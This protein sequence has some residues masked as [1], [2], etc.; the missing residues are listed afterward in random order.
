MTLRFRDKNLSFKASY[1]ESELARILRWCQD[2]NVP[3]LGEFCNNCKS[4]AREVKLHLRAD[5]RPAFEG[6]LEVVREAVFNEYNEDFTS[7]L[8]DEGH[9]TVLVGLNYLDQAYEVIQDGV[10]IGRVFFDFYT[11][12]WRFKP[13]A[14][15]C[16]RLWEDAGIGA[17]IQDNVHEK[18]EVLNKDH[19][20]ISYVARCG[21]FVPLVKTDGHVFGLGKLV[22]EDLLI[23]ELWDKVERAYGQRASFDDVIVANKLHLTM[24]E[25]RACKSLAQLHARLHKPVL[26]SYSGGKDSLA[27]LLIAL[28][29]GLEPIIFFND[30]GLELPETIENVE[31]V[32]SHFGLRLSISDAGRSFWDNFDSFGPPARDYRWCCK[33]CKLIPTSRAISSYGE[34]LSLV[35]QRKFESSARARSQRVWRNHWI[36]HALVT[37]PIN[38]WSMLHVW[39]YIAMRSKTSVV[40]RLYFKGFDR[41]GCFMCPACRI[42]EFENVRRLHPELWDKWEVALRGWAAARQL[43]ESWLTHHMWRWMRLPKRVVNFSKELGM[44]VLEAAYHRAPLEITSLEQENT[45][46]RVSFNTSIP[47][48]TL[49]NIAPSIGDV[50]NDGIAVRIESEA[51]EAQVTSESSVRIEVPTGGDVKSA[52]NKVIGLVARSILCRGCG[53]CANWCPVGAIQMVMSRPVVDAKLCMRC[54]QGRCVERCPVVSFMLNR[55]LDTLHPQFMCGAQ[56]DS[57]SDEN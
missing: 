11:L 49:I 5:P 39:L 53:S 41:I 57:G 35:G 12:S 17:V 45:F 18:N 26:V 48:D 4:R 32:T 50:H 1:K 29:S 33:V 44:D 38:D 19:Y 6:D 55:Y 15:G 54:A 28:R 22:A 34:V 14:Q 56:Y 2:C 20:R 31:E 21:T 13:L 8:I 3:V 7:S 30:T 51:F 25:S 27:V 24:Y 42:A 40:N 9:Q 23:V 52:L 43:P 16:L 47:F 10:S 37:S 46:A 36:R